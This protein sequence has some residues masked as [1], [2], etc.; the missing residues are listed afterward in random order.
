MQQIEQEVRQFVVDNFLFD[1]SGNSFSNDDS[2]I[3]NGIVD[4]MGIL[5]L[6]TFVQDTYRVRV[7]DQE[8]TTDNW[9]SVTRIAV[10]VRSKLAGTTAE[11]EAA[12]ATQLAVN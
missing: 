11:A 4:S 7:L 2:F 10:F 5:N 12:A 1:E 6:V 8:I 9:D 3:E